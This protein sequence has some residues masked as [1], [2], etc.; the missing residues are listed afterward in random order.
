MPGER[1]PYHPALL[2]ALPLRQHVDLQHHPHRTGQRPLILSSSHLLIFSSSH[3]FTISPSHPHPRPQ[4]TNFCTHKWGLRLKRRLAKVE[5]SEFVWFGFN[6][7]F[8]NI[9]IKYLFK[10][11]LC[12]CGRRSRAWSWRRTATWPGS[13]RP[14]TSSRCI[15]HQDLFMFRICFSR[16]SLMLYLP[17]PGRRRRRT[18]PPCP[19]PASSSTRCSWRRSSP[20]GM[21]TKKH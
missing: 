4:A 10:Y 2:P 3:P 11:L 14:L 12:R 8:S 6:I 15:F 18:S 16:I 7:F 5:V 9:C 17:R 19:P 20:G 13:P 1:G 21:E